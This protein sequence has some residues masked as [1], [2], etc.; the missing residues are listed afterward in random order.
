[1]DRDS[2]DPPAGLHSPVL[3]VLGELQ[4]LQMSLG[5][6]QQAEEAP[7]CDSELVQHP[8]STAEHTDMGQTRS[9]KQLIDLIPFLLSVQ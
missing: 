1:M 3:C 7:Q 5:V 8:A 9:E 2:P 4:H 6:V